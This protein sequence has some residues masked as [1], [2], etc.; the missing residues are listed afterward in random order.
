MPSNILKFSK[1]RLIT[2]VNIVDGMLFFTDGESEPKK[3]NIKKFR[4]DTDDPVDHTSGSTRIYNRPLEERDITVI[5][6]HPINAMGA[7]PIRNVIEVDDPDTGAEEDNEPSDDVVVIVTPGEDDPATPTSSATVETLGPDVFNSE[8][9]TMRGRFSNVSQPAEYNFYYTFNREKADPTNSPSGE[10]LISNLSHSDVYKV[11]T[12]FQGVAAVSVSQTITS[13]DNA[14]STHSSAMAAITTWPANVYYVFT[15]KENGFEKEIPG[16]LITIELKEKDNTSGEVSDF[17][18]EAEI[19]NFIGE[20]E[21][22][23]FKGIYSDD[24]GS[25]ITRKG[26]LVSKA[27]HSNNHTAPTLQ[28]IINQTND[29]STDDFLG[30]F[31]GKFSSVQGDNLFSSEQNAFIKT[32]ILDAE[33]GATYYIVAYMVTNNSSQ[34]IDGVVYSEN[35]FTD[36][37]PALNEAVITKIETRKIIPRV[38]NLPAS[39]YPSD[40]SG[41]MKA[42]AYAGGTQE[43]TEIGFL[44][45]KTLKNAQALIEAFEAGVNADGTPVASGYTDTFKVE[46]NLNSS[47]T[48]E[49]KSGAD[50]KLNTLDKLGALEYGETVWYVAYAKNNANQGNIK[51]GSNDGISAAS[52]EKFTLEEPSDKPLVV[53]ENGSNVFKFK[54]E[55]GA[56]MEQLPV[57]FSVKAEVQSMPNDDEADEFGIVYTLPSNNGTTIEITQATRSGFGASKE[58]VTKI[59]ASYYVK[60]KITTVNKNDSTITFS[61]VG[62]HGTI[63]SYQMTD[64]EFPRL[65]QTDIDAYRGDSTFLFPHPVVNALEVYAYVIWNNKKYVSNVLHGAQQKLNS[66]NSIVNSEECPFSSSYG[67]AAYKGAPTLQNKGT[68]T[69]NGIK[70]T[71]HQFPKEDVRDTSVTVYSRIGDDGIADEVIDTGFYWSTT[72]PGTG[73]KIADIKDWVAGAT[74][75]GRANGANVGRNV[76]LNTF[77][78]DGEFEGEWHTISQSID[79]STIGQ[80]HFWFTGYVKGKAVPT[81]TYILSTVNDTRYCIPKKVERA[82]LKSSIDSGD[83][84]LVELNTVEIEAYA[85]QPQGVSDNKCQVQLYGKAKPNAEYYSI[86][87]DDDKTFRGFKFTDASNI[88][89]PSNST[90][91]SYFTN[92]ANS[93]NIQTIYAAESGDNREGSMGASYN[94]DINNPGEY[95]IVAW[96][97]TDVNSNYADH[98][99]SGSGT[100]SWEKIDLTDKVVH[101]VEEALKLEV[102]TTNPGWTPI[103]RGKYKGTPYQELGFFIVGKEQEDWE[104]TS[105]NYIKTLVL[106]ETEIESGVIVGRKFESNQ[107]KFNNLNFDQDLEDSIDNSTDDPVRK[108]WKYYYCAYSYNK[109]GEIVISE[110]FNSFFKAKAIPAT[111]KITPRNLWWDH[112]G[113]AKTADQIDAVTSDPEAGENHAVYITTTPNPNQWRIVKKTGASAL[114]SYGGNIVTK[115]VTKPNGDKYLEIVGPGKNVTEKEVA[116]TVTVE[117]TQSGEQLIIYLK[118]KKPPT[119]T[120]SSGGSPGNQGGVNGTS[121]GMVNYDDT[122]QHNQGGNPF[123]GGGSLISVN[124]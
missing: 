65:S 48:F 32:G 68:F 15:V 79:W 120:T 23:R 28:D 40:K 118:Q 98:Y 72:N 88:S 108:G 106:A 97:Q 46:V 122:G 93:A 113:K 124:L 92:S 94:F 44:F 31:P 29:T 45:S 102:I 20:T 6:D 37:S 105:S 53:L 87:T 57:L 69:S 80:D 89:S 59:D 86:R 16:G 73:L 52:V 43:L 21:S 116:G 51:Y 78:G 62:E 99:S 58:D 75:F 77:R 82:P 63:G 84:P 101:V 104:V 100:P 64:H 50:F 83:E 60:N 9:L 8:I 55:T 26:F 18:V 61:P 112:L 25:Q 14:L 22:F 38:L 123:S 11:P 109:A 7:D 42:K 24:G 30:S 12:N 110:N 67:I 1:D 54:T 49:N 85:G 3:V 117:H 96:C 33:G 71:Y 103:I 2:A 91:H 81:S 114:W 27:Y 66:Q 10:T 107:N 74:R 4:G 19:G 36:G 34:G 95:I 56:N 5:K 90:V 70:H 13:T 35:S 121:T 41:D 119:N 76:D 47:N 111:I 17:T 39:V 115:I